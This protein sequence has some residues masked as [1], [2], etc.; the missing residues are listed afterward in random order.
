MSSDS[1]TLSVRGLCKSFGALAVAQDITLDIAAGDR[2]GLIGPNGAGKTT[3][4]NLLTGMLRPD[5]GEILLEGLAIGRLRP[6]ERVRRGLVRTHQINTLLLDTPARD[7]VAMAIAEREGIGWRLFRYDARW[8][9]CV[10]EAVGMLASMGLADDAARP[11]RELAYGKQ[12]LLEIA[13]ALALKPAVLLLDE[14]AAGVPSGES[15]AIHAMLER[16]PGEVAILMI[17]H[18]MD[19]VFRFARE[20]VVLVQGRVLTRGKPAQIAGDERVREVYLGRGRR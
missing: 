6:E 10:E 1:P 13:I 17:E 8:R 11:V 15:R 12:R 2:I 7:N 9:A 16:L 20:I 4:V 5:A 19:L 14:P 18:D 3:F